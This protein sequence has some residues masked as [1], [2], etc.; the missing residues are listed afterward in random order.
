VWNVFGCG[1][2]S[3]HLRVHGT[4]LLCTDVCAWSRIEG[5][6][7]PDTLKGAGHSKGLAGH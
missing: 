7:V 1:V 6:W 4:S 5:G 2:E 3:R